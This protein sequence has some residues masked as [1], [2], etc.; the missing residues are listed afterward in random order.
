MKNMISTMALLIATSSFA[1]IG[2]PPSFQTPINDVD[3]AI[4]FGVLYK[5]GLATEYPE[6]Q[7]IEVKNLSCSIDTLSVLKGVPEQNA[8][9]CIGNVGAK[10]LQLQDNAAFDLGSTLSKYGSITDSD[11]FSEVSINDLECNLDLLTSE[12]SCN[13]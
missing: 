1:G 8:W 5:T 7:Y 3:A 6:A 11:A 13:F 2:P 9:S 10:E 4:I 12:V